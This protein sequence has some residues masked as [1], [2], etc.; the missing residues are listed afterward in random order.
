MLGRLEIHRARRRSQRWNIHTLSSRAQVSRPHISHNS[1]FLG[2][3]A[4]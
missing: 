1:A 2:E 3:Q 4:P